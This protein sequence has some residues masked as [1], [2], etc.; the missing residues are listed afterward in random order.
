MHTAVFNAESRT[1]QFRLSYSVKVLDVKPSRWHL[2]QTRM[3]ETGG[4]LIS[5]ET[6][7]KNVHGLIHQSLD[8]AFGVFG[9]REKM[10]EY[11]R[12][13]AGIDH[14]LRT[15]VAPRIEREFGYE[16][17]FADFKRER[18]PAELEAIAL[19]EGSDRLAREFNA[20]EAEYIA[21]S[22]KLSQHRL[23]YVEKEDKPDLVRPALERQVSEARERRNEAQKAMETT[24][25][26]NASDL[27]TISIAGFSETFSRFFL[28]L[29]MEPPKHLIDF[30][31]ESSEPPESSPPDSA[32]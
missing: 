28:M 22:A 17:V 11:P 15:L 32:S 24:S 27:S 4:D 14:V 10:W 9:G 13:W 29:N 26:G 25:Y 6:E 7:I 5:V 23:A 12:F 8:H 3:K 2:A 19:L 21:I 31:S 20:A 18:T 30:D 16:V 1:G